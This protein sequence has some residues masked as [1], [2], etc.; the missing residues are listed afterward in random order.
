MLD[1]AYAG[2]AAGGLVASLSAN[3]ANIGPGDTPQANADVTVTINGPGTLRVTCSAGT[4]G[5]GGK[6]LL[7]YVGGV[8]VASITP[9]D[10][11]TLDATL[12]AGANTVHYEATKASSGTSWNATLTPRLVETGQTLASFTAAVS[13][14]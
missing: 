2:I 3:F 11:A 5:A 9:S 10:G 14:P 1:F 13:A 7:V 6:G 4:Y 8:N 12:A